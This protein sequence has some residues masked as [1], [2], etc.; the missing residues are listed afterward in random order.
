MVSSPVGRGAFSH[1]FSLFLGTK[2][3]HAGDLAV[4]LT[5]KAGARQVL[6]QEPVHGE[7]LPPPVGPIFGG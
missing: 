3:R 7:P 4:H 6:V 5:S 1:S 2:I